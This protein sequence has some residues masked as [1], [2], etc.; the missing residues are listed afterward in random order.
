MSAVKSTRTSWSVDVKK[1]TPSAS[2]L[3]MRSLRV[4]GQST[5]SK[6]WTWRSPE[7]KPVV[8]ITR[9]TIADTEGVP[10]LTHERSSKWIEYSV[11]C[12]TTTW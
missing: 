7:M 4:I 8:S 10:P 1:S 12:D 6:E 2:M 9:A 5:L 3:T 11:P